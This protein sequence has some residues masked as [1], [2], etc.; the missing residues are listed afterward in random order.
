MKTARFVLSCHSV[1]T[2]LPEDLLVNGKFLNMDIVPMQMHVYR[3]SHGCY[4]VA[5]MILV[6]LC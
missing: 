4:P 2:S 6:R 1:G 3:L 5:A